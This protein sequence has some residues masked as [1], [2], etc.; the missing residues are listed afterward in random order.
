MLKKIL[1]PLLLLMTLSASA[2]TIS[3]PKGWTKDEVVMESAYQA[4][5]FYSWRQSSQFHKYV[6]PMSATDPYGNPITYVPG[7]A[8]RYRK[9]DMAPFLRRGSSQGAINFVYVASAIGHV[10]ISNSIKDHVGRKY[11]QS[12][13]IG[14]EAYV[15]G[16]NYGAG[17]RVKW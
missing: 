2:Q 9:E 7:Y 14:L 8:E 4:L 11:W 17:V 15:I 10:V 3:I 16:G 5:L 13:T 6:V 1:L 12:A